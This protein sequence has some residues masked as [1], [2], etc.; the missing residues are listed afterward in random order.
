MPHLN[1]KFYRYF[2]FFLGVAATI[3][4]RIIVV[5]NHYSPRSV[6]IAW[7]IGT[8]GFVWYFAHRFRVENR[9]DRIITDLELV[10]KIEN[11]ENLSEL[12]RGSLV[13]VIKGLQTSLSKWNYIVIF[14]FSSLALIYGFLQDFLHLF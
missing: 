13:Y 14:V 9:R 10:K 8:I 12:E 6:Q 7:Y 2:M 1:S 3:A 4:Y 11:N 5:L